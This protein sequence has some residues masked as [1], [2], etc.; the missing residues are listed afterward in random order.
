M[1]LSKSVANWSRALVLVHNGKVETGNEGCHLQFQVAITEDKTGELALRSFDLELPTQYGE[2]YFSRSTPSIATNN[3]TAERG[4]VVFTLYS[5]EAAEENIVCFRINPQFTL[6]TLDTVP[7][8]SSAGLISLIDEDGATIAY[9]QNSQI[10]LSQEKQR[11]DNGKYSQIWRKRI[12]KWTGGN[13]ENEMLVSSTTPPFIL[14]ERVECGHVYAFFAHSEAVPSKGLSIQFAVIASH[15]YKQAA[16]Q[17]P[18]FW[19]IHT[20]EDSVKTLMRPCAIWDGRRT[21]HVVYCG[22]DYGLYHFS[23]DLNGMGLPKGSS[24]G[25]KIKAQGLVQLPNT[26]G[27][28]KYPPVIAILKDRLYAFMHSDKGDIL[29]YFHRLKD[30]SPKESG[31]WIQGRETG[32]QLRSEDGWGGVS[33]TLQEHYYDPDDS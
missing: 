7:G 30:P 22:P 9:T 8:A 20:M 2:K 4:Y 11:E 26:Q 3:S 18:I 19:D 25:A 14:K 15:F 29:V 13:S 5:D 12:V 33:V 21:I 27:K 23:F 1:R 6:A 16:S 10:I 31:K 28:V 32:I 24:H 17:K